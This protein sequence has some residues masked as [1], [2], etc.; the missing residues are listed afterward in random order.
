MMTLVS[1]WSLTYMNKVK[2]RKFE[3]QVEDLEKLLTA[4]ESKS[5]QDTSLVEQCQLSIMSVLD[6]CMRIIC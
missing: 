5:F 4:E 6:V 3:K 2:K 1:N